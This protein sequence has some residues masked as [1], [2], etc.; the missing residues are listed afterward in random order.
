MSSI[1]VRKASYRAFEMPGRLSIG[2]TKFYQLKAEG[3]IPKPSALGPR[4][5]TWSEEQV[6]EMLEFLRIRDEVI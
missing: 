2:K 4:A 3:V 5:H 6:V 1:P